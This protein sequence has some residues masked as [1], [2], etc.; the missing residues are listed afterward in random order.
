MDKRGWPLSKVK[1]LIDECKKSKY[2]LHNVGYDVSHSPGVDYYL[3]KI[4]SKEFPLSGINWIK[5]YNTSEFEV[6]EFC[7]KYSYGFHKTK[8]GKLVILQNFKTIEEFFERCAKNFPEYIKEGYDYILDVQNSKKFNA[9]FLVVG[10]N[11]VADISDL[12]KVLVKNKKEIV[13][14]LTV[15]S[16]SCGTKYEVGDEE[17]TFKFV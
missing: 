2:P 10:T 6:N 12:Q 17:F 7:I 3:Y 4:T 15:I 5:D 9:C 13:K 11:V 14:D 16:N 8:Y 1:S